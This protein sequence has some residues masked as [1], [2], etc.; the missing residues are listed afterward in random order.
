MLIYVIVSCPQA[1][2]QLCIH[3]EN[4]IFINEIVFYFVFSAVFIGE[5]QHLTNYFTFWLYICK[6]VQFNSKLLNTCE[7]INVYAF[8]FFHT[9]LTVAQ[10]TRMTFI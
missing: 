10:N 1:Q 3:N 7:N 5:G 6:F 8:V 2:G 4:C 9:I